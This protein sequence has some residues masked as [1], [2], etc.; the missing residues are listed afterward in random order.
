MLRVKNNRLVRVV[1]LGVIALLIVLTCGIVTTQSVRA[2]GDVASG[3]AKTLT[4]S[5]N[6]EKKFS[7]SS[8]VSAQRGSVQANY[9]DTLEYSFTW[10][11]ISASD[12]KGKTVNF[13]VP[14][15]KYMGLI[16]QDGDY[17]YVTFG[18]GNNVVTQKDN[19][20]LSADGNTITFDLDDDLQ[21]GGTTNSSGTRTGDLTLH[22]YLSALDSSS[23]KDVITS[24]SNDGGS[25]LAGSSTFTNAKSGTQMMPKL[26]LSRA[27]AGVTTY[28]NGT[29]V[30]TTNS[31]SA[32]STQLKVKSGAVIR[33]DYT[34]A[35]T[36][37]SGWPALNITIATGADG[38]K[39]AQ[40]DD[41]AIG[42]VTYKST[43]SS[44]TNTVALKPISMGSGQYMAMIDTASL[45]KGISKG[46]LTI[47]VNHQVDAATGKTFTS[48]QVTVLGGNM[49]AQIFTSPTYVVGPALSSS[50]TVKTQN[51]NYKDAPEVST[52]YPAAAGDV[53][54]YTYTL[55]YDAKNSEDSYWKDITFQPN[56]PHNLL[57][58]SVKVDGDSLDS[59]KDVRGDSLKANLGTLNADQ[60]DRD[61][62]VTKTIVIEA[63]VGDVG[64]QVDGHLK[65]AGDAKV[66]GT[67]ES[68]S[69][70]DSVVNPNIM[71]GSAQNTDV[72]DLNSFSIYN[73]G[74]GVE[75]AIK[76]DNPNSYNFV[77]G[78]T[79]AVLFCSLNTGN[80]SD[81]QFYVQINTNGKVGALT[82]IK[83]AANQSFNMIFTRNGV[84]GA[85]IPKPGWAGLTNYTGG[86]LGSGTNVVRLYALNKKTGRYA[87]VGSNMMSDSAVDTPY[88][89]FTFA[90]STPSLVVENN[91]KFADTVLTGKSQYAATDKDSDY[92]MLVKNADAGN[93]NLGVALTTAFASGTDGSGRK[94]RGDLLY[95]TAKQ[96]YTLNSGEQQLYT[97]SDSDTVE[98]VKSA[99]F[100]VTDTWTHDEYDASDS[101]SKSRGLYLHIFSDAVA[102]SEATNYT[103]ELT[104]TFSNTPTSSSMK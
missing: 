99:Q 19:V 72:I 43:T 58:H 63:A 41:G 3:A 54:R 52:K 95:R 51:L 102:D 45:M 62:K 5:V 4:V 16:K 47:S 103:G 67:T 10:Q 42:T 73:D 1:M 31:A 59:V 53:L 46:N 71:I 84:K 79:D 76:N 25:F 50:L 48:E 89:T 21:A 18:S 87:R 68:G 97:N 64:N 33:N 15:P 81:Y 36:N 78:D 66:T 86:T 12:L 30:D 8:D 60:A 7:T 90:D 49:G 104:W 69:Y 27:N 14:T 29:V 88:I 92:S 65:N 24:S 57:V 6:G 22:V 96:A 93:W 83:G 34:I 74:K 13:T 2:Q 35:D 94:L 28:Q 77:T 61:G 70:S 80:L 23:D 37:A 85:T 26:E 39:V 44:A 40:D 17:G 20:L 98:Q 101:G 55:T 91:V 56:L 9:G 32:G 100:N 38:L 75:T 82:P 11:N